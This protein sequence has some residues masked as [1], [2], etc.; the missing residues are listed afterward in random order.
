MAKYVI[1]ATVPCSVRSQAFNDVSE[2]WEDVDQDTDYPKVTITKADGTAVVTAEVLT[3]M[4]TG[5][6]RYLLS[7]IGLAAGF[8]KRKYE[9]KYPSGAETHYPIL[10]DG[11][12]LE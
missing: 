1:G 12:W 4:T 6:Y 7:T 9:G 3:R 10:T 11:F 8:Y 2:Q 5:K